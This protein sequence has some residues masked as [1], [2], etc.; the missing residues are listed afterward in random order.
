MWLAV[1]SA[2]EGFEKHV[3]P[4]VPATTVILFAVSVPVLSEQMAVAFPMVSQARRTR[5]KFFSLTSLL[6]AT[7]NAKV[8]ARG[9]PSGTATTMIVTATIKIFKKDEAFSAAV[10]SSDE[11]LARKRIRRTAKSRQA[12]PLPS[13]AIAM[14]RPSSFFCSGVVSMST[15]T[16][17]MIFPKLLLT[18]TDVATKVPVPAVQRY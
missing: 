15:R 2:L 5:T 12:A 3:D 13:F 4:K 9:R 18:P 8:T 17:T 14:A 11:R 6:V 10:R 1:D 7:A 16:D